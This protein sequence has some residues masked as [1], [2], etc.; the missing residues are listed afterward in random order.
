MSRLT[1]DDLE[2]ISAAGD[3]FEEAW[4]RGERPEIASIVAAAP[5]RLRAELASH[6]WQ[7][8][9]QL[10]EPARRVPRTPGDEE[11]RDIAPSPGNGKPKLI[12]L[13]EPYP[14]QTQPPRIPGFEIVGE[15]GR[16]GMGIVY[17][18]WHVALQCHVALKT[19]VP[20]A[21]IPRLRR[22]AQLIAQI[23]SPH[24]VAI[25][26][27]RTTDDGSLVLVMEYVEGTDLAREIHA[28]A[29]PLPEADVLTWMRHVA[30]G[31]RAAA[32]R[33]IIHRDL[34]PS[35]VLID[36][37]GAALVADFGLG[38]GPAEPL[39]DP[40][41]STAILGTPSYMA[42]EQAE[43]PQ[44]VDTRADIYSFGALF[45]HALTGVPPFEGRTH[46]VILYKHKTQPPVA[47]QA[48]NAALS[49][50]TS[51]ILER[52]LAKSPTDRFPSFEELL[53]HLG[54]SPGTA[55]PWEMTEDPAWLRYLPFYRTRRP[56]YLNGPRL[57]V[58]DTYEFPGG[59]RL[60]IVRGD[61]TAEDVEVLVSSEAWYLPMD[62][63]VALALRQAAGEQVAAELRRFVPL[64]PGRVV[65]TA[66]G[67]LRSRFLF[68]AV[69]MGPRG[70]DWVAPTRDLISEILDS[71]FYPAE[72]LNV[73]S[74]AFPLFGTGAGQLSR[75]VCLDTMFR[76]L[77]RRFLHR[78]TCVEEARIVI[79]PE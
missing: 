7:I 68:H 48:R 54:P 19:I 13:R 71:C 16:G 58:C 39:A 6:L 76:D 56:E 12:E 3:R 30:E 20:N 70:E 11:T 55:S 73:R 57:G 23:R 45:Y 25:H 33:G 22:E 17:K 53:R 49:D 5:G 24:V 36:R 52:C 26:D 78:P 14:A 41:P 50:R 29:G 62:Y 74:I 60:Q 15:L 18:A 47:P 44:G 77:S 75:E 61:L 64:R 2:L 43:D 79:Y 59:R 9:Q 21:S 51:Q 34:K 10:A 67:G 38:R 4:R 42:P 1:A 37:T 35:N 63:G 46:F 27:L 69:T 28:H 31:M 40:T 72:S 8:R 66:P 32:E 65:V